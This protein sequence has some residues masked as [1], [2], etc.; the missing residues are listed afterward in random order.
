M[1]NLNVAEAQTI[2]FN[3]SVDVGGLTL[4]L[5]TEVVKRGGIVIRTTVL[6]G[7]VAKSVKNHPVP[8][9]VSDMK[10]LAALVQAQH[11][12]YFDHLKRAG[13]SWLASI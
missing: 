4:H 8:P 5:Q 3:N 10:A 9:D 11:Q 7:G 6:D 1:S 12:R 13:A 2:G